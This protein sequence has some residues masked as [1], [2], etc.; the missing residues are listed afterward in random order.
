MGIHLQTIS[1]HQELRIIFTQIHN[2]F[3]EINSYNYELGHYLLTPYTTCIKI[4]QLSLQ[5]CMW[6]SQGVNQQTNCTHPKMHL[7]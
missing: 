7:D 4:Y 1:V 5:E 6:I 2:T 3:S